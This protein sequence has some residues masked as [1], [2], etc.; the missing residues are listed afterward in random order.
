LIT[1]L[2]NFYN[3]DIAGENPRA[4]KTNSEEATKEE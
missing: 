3:K 2:D 1:K 4:P